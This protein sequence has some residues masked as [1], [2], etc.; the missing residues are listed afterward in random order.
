MIWCDVLPSAC[1][2]A[3]QKVSQ[4]KMLLRDASG[5]KQPLIGRDRLSALRASGGMNGMLP[6]S[7]S[8][9]GNVAQMAQ[10]A[11]MPEK[12]EKS[13]KAASSQGPVVRQG[14]V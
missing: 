14:S 7:R 6:V 8:S 2:Q 13:E 1:T 4:Q 10:L 11:Q 12:S 5:S 3:L 9:S